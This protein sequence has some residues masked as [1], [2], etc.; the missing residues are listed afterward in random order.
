MALNILL[1]ALFTGI[2]SF[3]FLR[4]EVSPVEWLDHIVTVI[5]FISTVMTFISTI[6]WIWS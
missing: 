2:V 3:L 1:T 4:S 5:F 6:W